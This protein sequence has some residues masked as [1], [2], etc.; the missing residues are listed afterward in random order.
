[1]NMLKKIVIRG[2]G[3]NLLVLFAILLLPVFLLTDNVNVFQEL[4]DYIF[5]PD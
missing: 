4:V 1:M 2:I 5:K 3:S